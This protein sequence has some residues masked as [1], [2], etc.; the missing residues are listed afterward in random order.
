MYCRALR[1][2]FRIRCYLDMK[3]FSYQKI[4]DKLLNMIVRSYRNCR[5]YHDKTIFF[6]VFCDLTANSC[7]ITQISG[8]IRLFRRS[9]TNKYRIRILISAFIIRR[10]MQS[11]SCIISL[12]QLLQ[13]IF[14]NRRYPGFHQLYFIFIH[15]D[16]GNIMPFFRKTNTCYQTYIPGS[17]Y[18]K[19]HL[20]QSSL[21]SYLIS[22]KTTPFIT[23]TSG[24]SCI[25]PLSF[26][27]TNTG[28]IS[29]S[30]SSD[31]SERTSKFFE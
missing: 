10:I 29:C 5:F 15:I 19:L 3:L 16:A 27:K 31:T 24:A 1:Q 21:N 26:I 13:T 7:N 25:S 6:H 23:L 28:F 30:I 17:C 2:K 20:F 18:Y 9:D 4:F 22:L 11:S 12:H 8:A 14:I